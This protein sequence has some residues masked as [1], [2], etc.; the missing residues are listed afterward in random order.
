MIRGNPTSIL[1]IAANV[2]EISE[3]AKNERADKLNPCFAVINKEYAKYL[4]CK[5]HFH[6]MHMVIPS[7]TITTCNDILMDAQYK[8]DVV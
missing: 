4:L 8:S 5:I 1:E 6:K 3:P 2:S 7:S